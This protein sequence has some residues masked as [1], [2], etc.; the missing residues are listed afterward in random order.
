MC[1][2]MA[3]P[4][5]FGLVSAGVAGIGQMQAGKAQQRQANY[6]AEIARE[7]GRQAIDASTYERDR[8]NDEYR[9]RRSTTRVNAAGSGI[10]P[11]SGSAAFVIETD[12]T[13]NE[14][15]DQAT[16]LWNAQSKAAGYENKARDLI[17]DGKSKRRAGKTA[18]FGTFLGGLG[19]FAGS[20]AKSGAFRLG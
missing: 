14:Y 20:A 3:I 2:P 6:N 5:I 8:I 10:D 4:A 15:L 9:S 1:F 17:L 12:N 13:K 18:A 16:S 19:N 11:N 7:N